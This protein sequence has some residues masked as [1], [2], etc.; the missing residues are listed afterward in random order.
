MSI[1]G[2]TASAAIIIFLTQNLPWRYG[3]IIIFDIFAAFASHFFLDFIPHWAE[4]Y[5]TGFNLSFIPIILDASLALFLW[6]VYF[7]KRYGWRPWIGSYALIGMASLVPDIKYGLDHIFGWERDSFDRFH[8]AIQL[9]EN[10]HFLIGLLPQVI[11]VAVAYLLS[12][13]QRKHY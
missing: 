1:T 10:V 3:F 2:H 11:L 4:K 7:G 6:G 5:P 9:F 13:R 8:K 12:Q